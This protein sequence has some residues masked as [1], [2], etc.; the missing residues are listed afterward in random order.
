MFKYREQKN[1][2]PSSGVRQ[3]GLIGTLFFILFM[4]D[5]TNVF[6]LQFS[7][8][9]KIFKQIRTV[10][11]SINLQSDLDTILAWCEENKY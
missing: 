4:F 10:L 8:D 11:N 5:V 9:F 6:D 7:Y 3:G 1:R 2:K